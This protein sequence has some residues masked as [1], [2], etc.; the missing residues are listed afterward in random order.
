MKQTRT[1]LKTRWKGFVRDAK[2][3]GKIVGLAAIPVALLMAHICCEFRVTK[4]GY[5]I[6][7]ATT[8]HEKLMDRHR[9][10]SI[11]RGV[12]GRSERITA[13][14]KRRFGLERVEPD[15]IVELESRPSSE[16]P[17]DG[18]SRAALE[19]DELDH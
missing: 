14:A 1:W 13:Q 2:L 19:P 17:L 6:S 11:E 3:V 4:Y 18:S 12:E 9:K 10:L 7:E 8:R 16:S 5:Q 15:Q